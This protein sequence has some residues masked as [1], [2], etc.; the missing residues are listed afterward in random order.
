M[1]ISATKGPVCENP[2]N[3]N[4]IPDDLKGLLE[5]M[6]IR[7][8]AMRMLTLSQEAEGCPTWCQKGR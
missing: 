7:F 1:T 5:I 3:Q 4:E 8:A 2:F 6:D